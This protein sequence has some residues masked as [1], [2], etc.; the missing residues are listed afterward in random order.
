MKNGFLIFVLFVTLN[1]FS[2]DDLGSRGDYFTNLFFG[3]ATIESENSYKINGD[4]VGGSLGKE[5]I[6]SKPL[7]LI[8]A[9][10]YMRIQYEIP[11]TTN[12][13][14]LFQVNNFMKIPVLLRYGHQFADKSTIYAETGM[15][16]ASLYKL[17][18]ENIALNSS[19]KK[20]NV[21]YNFGLQMNLGFNYR[22][23]DIYSFG[24][25]LNA[26][27]DLFEFYNESVS[28]IKIVEMYSFQLRIGAKL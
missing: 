1:A 15:Y 23:S 17:K 27:A 25:G 11:E 14:P 4:V 22:L 21:G 2:Q 28:E 3:N 9:V 7:S 18:V 5:F 13:S 12:T 26:Q 20:N 24:F 10:E 8:T 6:L 16:V 19:Q